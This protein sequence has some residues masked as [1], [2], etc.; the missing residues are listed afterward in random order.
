MIGWNRCRAFLHAHLAAVTADSRSLILSVLTGCGWLVGRRAA[1]QHF[2]QGKITGFVSLK[3]RVS[4]VAA[5]PAIGDGR[6]MIE[7]LRALFSG[8]TAQVGCRL[9]RA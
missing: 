9:K 6:V 7:E 4:F 1:D 8:G 3:T 2:H 5:H